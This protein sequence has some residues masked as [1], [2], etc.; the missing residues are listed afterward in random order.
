MKPQAK[1]PA[2]FECAER[3]D[4]AA[5]EFVAGRIAGAAHLAKHLKDLLRQD[6]QVVQA[7][8]QFKLRIL[9]GGVRADL[10]R[11]QLRQQF[12]ILLHFEDAGVG[13]VEEIT[14]R[15]SAQPDKLLLVGLQKGEVG[16]GQWVFWHQGASDFLAQPELRWPRR[17][18]RGRAI[19][20]PLCQ[21]D[22]R[23]SPARD[24]MKFG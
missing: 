14:F 17:T 21:R 7:A 19:N 4:V 8:Q 24:H 11:G 13:V 10:E 2:E 3:G 18:C 15:Q 23:P 1:L 22:D 20:R 9:G 16:Y 6:A 5:V 12:R